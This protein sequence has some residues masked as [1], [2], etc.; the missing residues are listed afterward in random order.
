MRVGINFVTNTETADIATLARKAEEVGFDSI[1]VGEH[2]L[3]PLDSSTRY[4]LRDD[5]QFPDY[6]TTLP[7]PLI[8]LAMAASVTSTIKLCTSIC[9]V[10]E[11]NFFALTKAV[12]TLDL[13]SR[14]RV[15]FGI[16]AGYV[17]E[18]SH[19]SSGIDWNS[20]YSRM[21]ESI[22][23]MRLLWNQGDAEYHG[24][25][26]DFPLVRVKP[27]PVQRP[28]PVLIGGTGDISKRAVARWADGW[29]PA[30]LVSPAELAVEIAAIHAE[31]RAHG[32]D[33]AALDISILLGVTDR[34]DIRP[35]LQQYEEAGVTRVIL[36][37]GS[38][39]APN[40]F[41]SYILPTPSTYSAML[42]DLAERSVARL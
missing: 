35:L 7:D 28:I 6:Y 26:I 10:N 16:G 24:K 41:R 12:A 25:Q 38:D 13:W 21:R 33:P 3:F 22:E 23:A 14:G 40:T 2:P 36:L 4:P 27:Q 18:E 34:T 39:E 9:L 5:G 17:P 32:R 11:H 1:W 30:A 42:E 37:Y 8:G 29:C 20:R 31:A 15:I 19:I